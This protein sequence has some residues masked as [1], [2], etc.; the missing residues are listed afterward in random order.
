[1]TKSTQRTKPTTHTRVEFNSALFA[2]SF[3]V[4]YGAFA[5]LGHHSPDIATICT[6]VIPA[7]LAV[8]LGFTA[9]KRKIGMLAGVTLAVSLAATYGTLYWD[10]WRE[11]TIVVLALLGAWLGWMGA[12]VRER[13]FPLQS[14]DLGKVVSRPA[15]LEM[16]TDLESRLEA[17][18]QEPQTDSV[19]TR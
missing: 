2:L 3:P 12:S 10:F 14:P 15:I 8:L 19:I 4:I 7:P 17:N 1:V 16:L 18:K 5:Y 13:H 9:G 11:P 6:Q